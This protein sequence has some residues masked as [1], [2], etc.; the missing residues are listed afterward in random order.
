MKIGLKLTLGFFAVAF[1]S[2]AVIGVISFIKGKNSLEKESFNRLKAVREMKANQIEDYYR[3]ITDQMQTMA[4]DPTIIEGMKEFKRGFYSVDKDLGV[5]DAKMSAINTQ[6]DSYFDKQYLPRLNRNLD[7]KAK[8]E[9]ESST[10]IHTRILQYLY[11]ASNSYEVGS[12]YKLDDAR[13]QSSWTQTH[14][15]FH[16]ILRNYLQKFGYYDVFLVDT[17]GNIVYT[18][19]KEVDFGTSL[20]TGPFSNT[21][22]AEAYRATKKATTRD[23]VTLVD[24]KPYHPS[25]NAS[26]SFIAAPIFDG[27]EKIGVLIF[28]MPID[29]INDIMTSKREWSKVGLGRTG[30][31]YIVGDDFTLRNQSRFLIEDSTNYFRMIRDIGLPELTVNR[32]RN[33]NSSIGLQRVRT[34]G[35]EAALSGQ[36]GEKIFPDYRG[37]P[38]LSSF[39]PLK[40]KG[41]H[42]VIMSELDEAEA[43]S[44]VYLLRSQIFIA[45][46]IL[47]VLLGILSYIFSKR[48]TRSLTILT[49]DARELARGNFDKEIN[50]KRKDEIGVLAA[51]FRKMQISIKNLVEELREINQNLEKKVEDRT[52]EINQQKQL[53]EHQNKEILDSINYALRLQQAILPTREVIAETL[54]DSFVLFKPK[55]IVSGD[56]YWVRKSGPNVMAAVVDCTGHGVP[57]ALVSIVGA[58]SLGRCV[59]EF[60]LKKPSDILE[61]LNELVIETFESTDHEIKDGMD[62]SMV[63]LEQNHQGVIV[64]Y[65]GANNPLWIFRAKTGEMEEIKADKQP[66]GKYDFRKPFTNH[67]VKMEK[68]DII[69]LFSDGYADQF[70]GPNGKKFK[71]SMLKKLLLDIHTKPMEEQRSILDKAFEDWKGELAQI[72]DVCVMGIRV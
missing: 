7:T 66:I 6:L 49:E 67:E 35:T 63:S 9:D 2:M 32:I 4:E 25:Y 57:G 29:R 34:R 37:V 48:L 52:Q 33:F 12:K 43:F 23:F 42:W 53:V 13:D 11:I 44:A 38:V 54:G 55:D 8:R 27:N 39:R 64:H 3:Q 46:G 68:G 21:N 10:D 20:E 40:I 36:T 30:E 1:A 16:P 62:L 51:S 72:D 28:Q 17:T 60:S 45:F 41:M 56:F 47:I 31:T 15:K 70:G 18:C 71:Y 14:K 65:S 61:K 24:F 69:Y 22:I 5:N 58:S 19:F 59:G 26:A 50:I